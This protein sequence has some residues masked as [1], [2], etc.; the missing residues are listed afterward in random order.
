MLARFL[1]RMTKMNVKKILSLVLAL[2]MVFAL[3]APAF[4][5]ED[6]IEPYCVHSR[7]QETKTAIDQ[8][9][10]SR[11]D[12]CGNYSGVHSHFVQQFRFKKRCIDCEYV[13]YDYTSNVVTCP[14]A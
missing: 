2:V 14:Y 7:T 8:G 3:A 11:A 4:A 5:E 10:Y 13:F 6:G 9:H 1:E 12:G